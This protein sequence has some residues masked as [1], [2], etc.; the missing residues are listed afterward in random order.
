MKTHE[1]YKLKQKLRAVNERYS[2]LLDAFQIPSSKSDNI[3]CS[4]YLLEEGLSNHTA[5][6]TE[7][8]TRLQVM[9]NKINTKNL[10]RRRKHSIAAKVNKIK[11]RKQYKQKLLTAHTS[12]LPV[13]GKTTEKIQTHPTYNLMKKLMFSKVQLDEY[14]VPKKGIET[15]TKK[16]LRKALVEKK[17]LNALKSEGD[18][19][20]YAELK[21]K[22]AWDRAIAKTLGQK[23]KDDIELLSK[24][25][26][27]R[28]KRVTKSKQ[29]WAE[30]IQKVEHMK[31]TKQKQRMDN[32]KT[33]ADK[34]KNKKNQKLVKKGR[35]IPGF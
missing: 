31:A 17:N 16:L 29:E 35:I 15:D 33:R 27:K 14:D 28:K 19:S 6:K 22:K 8:E 5:E 21:N 12:E 30:R 11:L 32:I 24:N 25:I 13:N 20:T 34:K 18:K 2:Y 3:V 4:D 1:K 26:Q 10:Q 23:V 9:Q 7:H